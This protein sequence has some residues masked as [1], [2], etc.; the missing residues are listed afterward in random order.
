MLVKLCGLV[1]AWSAC[2]AVAMRIPSHLTEKTLCEGGLCEKP[3]TKYERILPAQPGF[4]WNDAGGY[5]G[6]WAIQRAMLT[7]GAYISQGQTRAHT[8]PGGGNDNEIL[9]TNIEVAFKNLKILAE[10]FDYKSHLLPQQDA[11]FRWL[12]K[13]LVQGHPVTWMIMWDGQEYPIYGLEPPAGLYGHVEP[14]IGIQSNHPLTDEN[15]YDDDVAVHFT[16]GG[17]NTVYKP[18]S[19]LGGMWAKVGDKGH[20]LDGRY[21]IG[22]Y[23]FGWGIQGYADDTAYPP[24]HLSLSISP[25]A[26]E[27]DTR[28]GEP[29]KPIHGTVTI[30]DVTPG[31]T[32]HLYRW[33]SVEDAL[34]YTPEF[35][36][37]V[38]IGNGTTYTYSDPKPFMSDSATYYRAIEV[39]KV[40]VRSD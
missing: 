18:I 1:A 37:H 23:S 13:Q 21:C 35:K 38:F 8:V 32:Y 26:S 11:Y 2:Q 17:L 27:P 3:I 15:V 29:P 39:L 34:T 19:S 6:S 25:S 10:G 33:D 20:C 7:K 12:K 31:S 24:V 5:C 22:P 30:S 28:A 40:P 9:S 14:V 36:Y 16:D 4:Q